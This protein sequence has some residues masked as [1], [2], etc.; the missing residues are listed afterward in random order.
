MTSFYSRSGLP[1]KTQTYVFFQITDANAFRRALS[2]LVPV[3]TST[4]QVLRHRQ[5]ITDN[6][7]KAADQGHAPQLLDIVGVNIA[8]SHTGLVTVGYTSTS[9]SSSLS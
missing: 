1:K 2:D 6:K 4:E 3:I 9:F 5:S 8:F 7:K